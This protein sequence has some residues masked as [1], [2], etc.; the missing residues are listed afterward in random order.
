MYII[1]TYCRF[2]KW[3]QQHSVYTFQINDEWYAIKEVEVEWGFPVLPIRFDYDL[4]VEWYKLYETQEEAMG[5]VA[6][7]K[8]LNR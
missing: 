2:D 1:D 7:L 4:K 3:D 5:Y 8:M 6:Q